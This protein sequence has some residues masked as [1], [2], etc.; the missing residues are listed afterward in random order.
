MAKNWKVKP[1]SPYAS[2]LA[3]GTGIST[4]QAQLLINRGIS[5]IKSATSFLRPRLSDLQDP[6]LLKDMDVAVEQILN[7]IKGQEK[8]TIYGDYDVDGLTSTALLFNFF[9]D[10]DIPVSY[11]IPGR[12]SEG[13]GL[14]P[15]AVE[16]IAQRGCDLMITVDCGTANKMEIEHAVSRGMKVV[17]TDHHQVPEDFEPICPVINP[18]RKD[19]SFPFNNLAGVGVSFFLAIAVRAALRK[20]GWFKNRPEPDLRQFLDLVALGTVADMVQLLDQNRILV[21][22]GI[23]NMG[24][25]PWP[26]IKAMQELAD[27]DNWYVTHHDLAFKLAPRLNAPGRMGSP[28]TGIQLL[29][30]GNPSVARNLARQLNIMNNQRQSI[31]RN[32]LGQVEETIKGMRDLDSRRT[33]VLSGSSWHIGVLGIVASRL[34]QKYNRPALVLNVRDGMATGSGRTIDG[35]NLY[36]ALNKLRHLFTK[37]GGHYRA[38]GFT[39]GASH[40]ETLATELED[41]ARKELSE[42]D[43][44][45]TIEIDSEITLSDLT[46]ETVHG[47]RLL[48]PFGSG[49]PEPLFYTRSLLVIDSRVVGER[50]LKLKVRQGRNVKEAIGFGLS[51]K[52]PLEGKIIHIIFTPEIN[53]WKGYEKIQ[54]RIIGLEVMEY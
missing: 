6:M 5:D 48:S 38:V 51:D 19:S 36:H 7:S 31:E 42:E 21:S 14:H 50:H 17:V 40:V 2:L 22:S 15:E 41:L 11:Y 39:L 18:H 52:H 49:N 12:L 32:I 30:T 35:F 44:I 23:E 29:T 47:L 45:P 27:I 26:W 43:L 34:T 37:F 54:L 1:P 33:L 4:L 28:E 8:I 53:K 10:L 13:F 3:D 46:M 16:R 24:T 20:M 9:S 25:S